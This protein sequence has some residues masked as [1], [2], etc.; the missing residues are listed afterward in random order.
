ME[1]CWLSQTQDNYDEHIW[2]IPSMLA[3]LK[4]EN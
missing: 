2:I 4:L 1:G 3:P